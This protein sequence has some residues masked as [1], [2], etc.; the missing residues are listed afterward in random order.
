MDKSEI[1]HHYSQQ[2]NT[3]L[4]EIKSNVLAMG[5]L[6]EQQLEKA[7]EALRLTEIEHAEEVVANDYKVNAFDVDIDE[8]CT[9]ILALRQPTASDLRLVLTVI[10][11]TADL[12]RIGDEAKRVA[13]MAIRNGATDPGRNLYLRIEHL[14]NQVRDMLH[15]ALDSFARMDVEEAIAVA[16]EDR[17]IDREYESIMRQSMTYMMEDP[18]SIPLLM[19]IIWSA[20]ALERVGDRCCNICEYVIYFV[21]G[22][23]VRHTSLE[24]IQKEFS[25]QDFS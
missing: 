21:K 11:T 1:S 6:V 24:Q 4:E 22:K 7:I 8:R 16:H 3:D 17:K 2:F 5:G 25:E 14:G 23:D 19:D 9:K 12:E 20:R 10:K 15:R 13:R 18:R